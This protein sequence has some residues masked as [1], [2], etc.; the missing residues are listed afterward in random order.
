MTPK[1]DDFLK[2]LLATFKVEAGEH[3]NALASGL[4]SLEQVS[5]EEQAGLLETVFREAHSLKGAARAVN[6]AEIETICQALESVFSS[7]KRKE[8]G[9]SPALF[10]L[11]HKAVDELGKLLSS[12]ESQR[13]S[14]EQSIMAQQIGRASCRE[15][16][17]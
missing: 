2:K 10:D 13:N 16:V 9:L 4:V 17:L 7:L 14:A 1:S 5:G 6:Q 11:L 3:V 15:R 12:V 8:I